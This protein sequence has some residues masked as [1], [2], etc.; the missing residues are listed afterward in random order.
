ML[1]KC[2]QDTSSNTK[3][4][5]FD[6]VSHYTNILHDLGLESL[7]YYRENLHPRFKKEFVIESVEFILK[8]NTITFDSEFFLETKVLLWTL[9]LPKPMQQ[10]L[11]VMLR[12][13]FLNNSKAVFGTLIKE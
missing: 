3:I 4:V 6:L 9:H 8:N 10:S 13:N 11:W 5:T 12:S 1:N 7:K 2:Q